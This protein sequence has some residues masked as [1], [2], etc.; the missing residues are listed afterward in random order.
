[1]SRHSAYPIQPSLLNRWSPRALSG[2]GMSEQELMPLFEAARWAPSSYNA[3]PWRFIYAHRD[4]PSWETF[5]ALLGE[6]N[7]SWAKNAAVLVVVAS[8]K[9]F[10]HNGEPS[11]THSF[12]AGAAWENLALEASARGIVAHGMQGF[13]YAR[14]VS[15][16]GIPSEF[17][18]NAMI[19]IGKPGRKEDLPAELQEREEPSDRRP[20]AEIAMEGRF[21]A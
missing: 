17:E 3:Q 12:D 4:T 20:L 9:T 6:F 5:F 13:D 11:V 21:R 19:A 2:D 16:L 15:E 10:E 18:V 7:Q 8:R 1:M 14:A